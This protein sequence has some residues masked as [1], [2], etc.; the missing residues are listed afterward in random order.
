MD[1]NPEST[2][3]PLRIQSPL[4]KVWLDP[5]KP[6]WKHLT[7]AGVWIPTRWDPLR[8]ISGFIPSCTFLPP[9]L[10]RVCWGCNYLITTGA[11]SCRVKRMHTFFR[12]AS[13]YFL[14]VFFF[15]GG[16]SHGFLTRPW[17]HDRW[18]SEKRVIG[19]EK[20]WNTALFRFRF[21]LGGGWNPT[22]NYECNNS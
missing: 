7:S 11:P 8:T 1:E 10:N 13:G 22:P 15:D 19:F 20:G 5:P 4:E 14:R 6:T 16:G 9:S 2:N 21:F 18:S 17:G 3:S 12:E